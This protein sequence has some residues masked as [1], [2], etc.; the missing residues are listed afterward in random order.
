MAKACNFAVSALELK[1]KQFRELALAHAA[2][3]AA[4]EACLA[5]QNIG[6]KFLVHIAEIYLS[7][8]LHLF[9]MANLNYMSFI[10]ITL[11]LLFS[12]LLDYRLIIVFIGLVGF[13]IVIYKTNS[14]NILSILAPYYLYENFK[15]HFTD[16]KILCRF[17]TICI[18]AYI[19]GPIF[20]VFTS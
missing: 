13:L 3:P 18:L 5:L 6:Y 9:K 15:K 7:L 14:Y 10:Y 19:F 4:L 1:S 11:A 8:I 20:D 12:L 17:T 16:K 2:A